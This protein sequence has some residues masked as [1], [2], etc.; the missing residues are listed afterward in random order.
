MK[1][2]LLTVR[3]VALILAIGL[4]VVS[5]FPEPDAL[6]TLGSGGSR[7]GGQMTQEGGAPGPGN[8]SDVGVSGEGPMNCVPRAPVDG[9][10]C[11]PAQSA[12]PLAA[13]AVD[14]VP[15]ERT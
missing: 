8:I 12:E 1:H 3:F 10:Q 15:R 7:G 5:C 2:S 14:G 6:P 9:A 11:H 13:R 4:S